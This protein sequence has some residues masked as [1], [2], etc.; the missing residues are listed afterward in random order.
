[1]LRRR[2]SGWYWTRRAHASRLTSLRGTGGEPVK[3]VEATTGRLVGTV[4]EPSAHVIAHEGATYLHQGD[5]YLVSS[6]DLADGAA[7][8]RAV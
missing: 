3:I 7:L 1:M 8:V 6:L 4:D 5:T 2:P